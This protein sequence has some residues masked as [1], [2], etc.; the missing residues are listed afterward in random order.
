MTLPRPNSSE[1][2]INSPLS[3]MYHSPLPPDSQTDLKPCMNQGEHS[4]LHWEKSGKMGG[5]KILRVLGKGGQSTG[6]HDRGADLKVF[7]VDILKLEFIGIL[8]QQH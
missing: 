4:I 7:L 1:G 2:D 3:P 8:N 5:N 6:I